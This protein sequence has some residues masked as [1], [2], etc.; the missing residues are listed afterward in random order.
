M[1]CVMRSPIVSL[2][3]TL[4]GHIRFLVHVVCKVGMSLGSDI[5]MLKSANRSNRICDAVRLLAVNR[6][7][8]H[9]LS[10]S[11]WCQ[12]KSPIQV[13]LVRLI[14]CVCWVSSTRVL[15]IMWRLF[16]W[17]PSLYM[18]RMVM[19]PVGILM[20]TSTISWELTMICCHELVR[21]HLLMWLHEIC[22][23]CCNGLRV[24]EG[25]T[26]G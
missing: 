12:L 2:Q 14:I 6:W 5:I 9:S 3:N 16:E 10:H 17:L 7:E 18:L 1:H 13:I 23:G 26:F 8:L 19:G 21:V 20:A 22:L 25:T 11:G 24:K 4:S 15:Q